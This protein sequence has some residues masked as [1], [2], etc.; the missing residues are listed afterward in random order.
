[1][2]SV[3]QTKKGKMLLV[4][5]YPDMAEWAKLGDMYFDG[6]FSQDT[7]EMVAKAQNLSQGVI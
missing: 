3:S 4:F 1:M 5:Y 7:Q 2:A 6:K